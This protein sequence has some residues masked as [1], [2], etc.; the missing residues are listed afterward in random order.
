MCIWL[1]KADVLWA[2]NL[3]LRTTSEEIRA[4]ESPVWKVTAAWRLFSFMSATSLMSQLQLLRLRNHFRWQQHLYSLFASKSYQTS[5]VCH[6]SDDTFQKYQYRSGRKCGPNVLTALQSCIDRI[7]HSGA[8]V[9]LRQWWSTQ[10]RIDRST[11]LE[12]PWLPDVSMSD[13]LEELGYKILC[14]CS[15]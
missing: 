15:G 6:P 2:R 8:A 4:F 14:F 12:Y 10:S 7:K 13:V 1:K 5:H 9:W 3:L 11:V